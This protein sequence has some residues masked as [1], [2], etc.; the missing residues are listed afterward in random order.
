MFDK[1][2]FQH[3]RQTLLARM[4]PNSLCL[5]PGANL[6]VR[7][8]DTHYPFR[9]DSY[10]QYLS[11]FPEPDAYLV[12]SNAE[13]FPNGLSILFCL[14]KDPKREIWQG[15]RCGPGNAKKQYGI[16][17]AFGEDELE[18][19]LAEVMDGHQHLYFAQGEYAYADELVFSCLGSQSMQP[20]CSINDVRP[21]LDDMRLFKSP[22]ELA[23]MEEAGRISVGAHIRAMCMAKPGCFEYQLAAE[24][25]HEFAMHGATHPAYGT[26]V[27]GGEN[28]CILHYTQN[29]QV[30]CDGDLVL[31]DA[32]GEWQGYAADITR[33]FPVSGRFSVAQKQLY[34]LVLDAQSAAIEC[35]KPGNTLKQATD[36]AIKIIT[37]GLI[38]LGLLQGELASNIREHR[39]RAFFMHGLSHWLG[40]DVHDVGDYKVSDQDRPLEIGMV[41][42][43]EP[44]IY[45]A[46]NA[47]VD[48]R[49]RGIGIRIEDN[50]VITAGGYKNLTAGA[51]KQIWEIEELMGD[52][53]RLAD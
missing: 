51:P 47:K 34:Q 35:L 52:K 22:G 46:M 38:N 5:I 45:I 1:D 2:E 36:C 8:R 37:Q 13:A 25:H 18:D 31:I 21:L 12:L 30:L 7:S 6:Q 39:Y 14:A 44:G 43:V 33:T 29:S 49:W 3:R 23:L 53:T 28:A 32:G 41:L 11:G 19:R 17:L 4:Q 48:S 50:V 15:R 26:I 10:L 24:I 27:A 42:T 20:P 40:L 16:D 9:Q